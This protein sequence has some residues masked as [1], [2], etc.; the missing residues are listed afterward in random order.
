MGGSCGQ[1]VEVQDVPANVSNLIVLLNNFPTQGHRVVFCTFS[2]LSGAAAYIDVVNSCQC[3]SA[4]S[5]T[6]P[7]Q[8]LP[9]GLRTTSFSSL[10]VDVEIQALDSHQCT[11]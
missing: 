3:T 11:E 7:V 1:T 5:G 4:Q 8:W 2:N 6:E 9:I 10:P